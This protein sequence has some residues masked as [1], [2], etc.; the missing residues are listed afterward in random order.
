MSNITEK[1]DQ[2]CFEFGLV[3]LWTIWNN[4]NVVVNVMNGE[5]RDSQGATNF[6]ATF[7]QEY[8]NAMQQEEGRP[9]RVNQKWQKPTQRIIK[10]NFDGSVRKA[11]KSGGVES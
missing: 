5:N 2:D 10:V 8:K 1:M 4:C 7:F 11:A 3:V 9:N 6:A